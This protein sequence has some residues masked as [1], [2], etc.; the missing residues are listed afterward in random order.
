MAVQA[1]IFGYIVYLFLTEPTAPNVSN[2]AVFILA[3]T[4]TFILTVL[5]VIIYRRCE[6]L[7][8]KIKHWLGKDEAELPSQPARIDPVF[9][10][11]LD[12]SITRLPR[13]DSRPRIG[14]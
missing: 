7:F 14:K 5:P 3:A 11:T 4:V 6:M 9:T 2:G 10:E 13:S 1:A 8:W 12:H